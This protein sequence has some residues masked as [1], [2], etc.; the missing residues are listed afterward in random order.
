MVDSISGVGG[1][2]SLDGTR[3]SQ[4]SERNNRLNESRG[5]ESLTPQDRVELSEEAISLS[6]AQQA[7]GDV[8]SFLEENSSQTLGL[9]P[10]FDTS[11]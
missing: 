8:R 2:Q 6:Q 10:N 11:V 3:R 9:D 7:A 4:E 5:S 1:N